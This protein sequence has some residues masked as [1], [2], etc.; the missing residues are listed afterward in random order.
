MAQ[1]HVNLVLNKDEAKK[2]EVPG[3]EAFPLNEA[4]LRFRLLDLGETY[5]TDKLRRKNAKKSKQEDAETTGAL[6]RGLAAHLKASVTPLLA[7]LPSCQYKM[8]VSVLAVEEQGQ[9]LAYSG[10]E[11]WDCKTDHCI[12][13]NLRLDGNLAFIVNAYFIRCDIGDED[14]FT[15]SS[16]SSDSD[17][18]SDEGQE[19]HQ[20]DEKGWS[21]HSSSS[22]SSS[23]SST[24]DS[25][26]SSSEEENKL[27]SLIIDV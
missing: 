19:L 11:F 27:D 8:V 24:S 3:R 10:A 23:S 25:S 9:P 1:K 20:R 21:G 18:S 2:C 7:S 15:S 4:D 5:L 12:L 14:A 17:S 26:Y 16:S 6:A 22:N 13:A